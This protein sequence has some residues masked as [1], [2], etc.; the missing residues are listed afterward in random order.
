MTCEHKFVHMETIKQ[1]GERPSWG[2]S[3]GKQWKRTDRFFC[4]KCLT[5]QEKV[6]TAEGWEEKP[7]W[8]D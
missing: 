3:S 7:D 6:Q 2:F 4:E 8:W 5:I 1:C